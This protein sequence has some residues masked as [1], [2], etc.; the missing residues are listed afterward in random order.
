MLKTTK[1]PLKWRWDLSS[2]MRRAAV[3]GRTRMISG[4]PWPVGGCQK[5]WQLSADCWH[6]G[7]RAAK[8]IIVSLDTL[9]NILGGLICYPCVRLTPPLILCAASNEPKRYKTLKSLFG[10]WN[11]F[12]ACSDPVNRLHFPLL[13]TQL[14]PH[15]CPFVHVIKSLK[16][17]SLSSG[18]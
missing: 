14:E 2:G 16:L 3:K 13:S 1:K 18:I 5:A 4:S 12:Q 11:C 17:L 9:K 7:W 6:G 10:F 8:W 15:F